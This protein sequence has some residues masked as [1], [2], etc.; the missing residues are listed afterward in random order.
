MYF[1]CKQITN[2]LRTTK[3]FL[4]TNPSSRMNEHYL[5][6]RSYDKYC[7]CLKDI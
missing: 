3:G 6:E 5:I 4:Q 7:V 1:N 2:L